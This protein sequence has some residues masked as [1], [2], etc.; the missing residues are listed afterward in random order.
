MFERIWIMRFSF[1][2]LI[3][4]F[5]VIAIGIAEAGQTIERSSKVS[6]SCGPNGCGVSSSVESPVVQRKHSRHVQRQHKARTNRHVSRSVEA[7]S[8]SS[9]A[10]QEAEVQAVNAPAPSAEAPK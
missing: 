4:A 3:A 1:L 10:V 2:C 8:S 5:V 7:S 6:R 9:P